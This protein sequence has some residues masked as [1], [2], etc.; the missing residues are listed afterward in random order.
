MKG[1]NGVIGGALVTAAA[2]TVGDYFW[3]HVAHHLPVY[4]LLH[5]ALLFLIVGGYLGLRSGKATI[6]AAG[7]AAIG[8]LAA[9]SFYVLQ[10]MFGYSPMFF[11][12]IGVWIGLG[13]LHGRVLT[14]QRGAFAAI[15]PRSVIAA[16]GTGIGFYAI[17]GIWF[18]FHPRG[19]DYAIHFFAWTVAYLPGFAALLLKR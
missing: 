12:Y 13:V 7:G 18:P 15:L 9:G 2:S 3:A 11:L 5:G 1:I 4:G 6:G 19:W 14:P 10:P 16:V 17:S 8:F